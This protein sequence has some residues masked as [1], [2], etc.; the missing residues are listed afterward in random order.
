M[1]QGNGNYRTIDIASISRDLLRQWWAILL[2]SITAAILV[3]LVAS[4]VYRPV[5]A[6]S[7][8]FVVTTRGTNTSIYENITSATDTAARFQTI[9][10]S[11]ILKRA[12]AK[13]L[14]IDEYNAT[15]EVKLLEETNLIVL[16]VKHKS[17]LMAYRY[18]QSI[19]NNYS[20]VSDFV[21]KNVVLDVIQSPAIPVMPS[22]P[23][24]SKLYTLLGFLVGL[25]IAVLYVAYFSYLKDTVKNSKEASSKLAARLL[26]TVYHEKVGKER[27]KTRKNSMVITN[28]IL[29]FRYTESCRMA[30][31]RIR[32]RMDRKGA[33]TLLVTSVAENEGKSTVASNIAVSIAQEGKNVLLIDADFRKPSLYK[34]F[35]IDKNQVTNL[36][37]ILR[38]GVGMQKSIVKLKKYPLYFILNNTNTG[39]ID[40]VLANNRFRSL[41]RFSRTKFDYIILDTAPMGLVPDAEG[42]AEL[43]DAS[44]IVVREDVI[45]AKNINDAIDTLNETNAKVLG[46]VFNDAKLRGVSAIRTNSA[47]N[48]NKK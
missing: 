10:E 25:A 28:P 19:M 23:N 38:S 44:L 43:C 18:I 20:V 21:I 33:K 16:T 34:I 13:D 32:S 40:D 11:N 22:N 42:I 9:L 7:T 39:S 15:T 2:F 48:Y 26:G 4:I 41:I 37:A 46:I 27:R 3:N 17:A 35:D 29:S 5:Y 12:I 14:N 45:L 31:S 8:T 47:Y 6:T 36:V 1:N 30:A 24:R